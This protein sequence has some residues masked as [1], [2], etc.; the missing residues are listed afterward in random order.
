MQII[1]TEQ[2]LDQLA[3]YINEMPTKYGFAVAVLLNQWRAEAIAEQA[4]S[5]KAPMP[6]ITSE[7]SQCG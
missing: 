1:L 2:R 5:E 6:E 4:E 7:Q 3:I